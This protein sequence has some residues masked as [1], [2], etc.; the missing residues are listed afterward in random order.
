[1]YY[2]NVEY[3]NTYDNK[4]VDNYDGIMLTVVSLIVTF[5]INIMLFFTH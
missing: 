2:R 5:F 3:Y 4:T 1:M